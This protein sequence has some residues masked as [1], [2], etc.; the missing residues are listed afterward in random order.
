MKPF[1]FVAVSLA[2]VLCGAAEA[3]TAAG[4]SA[5]RGGVSAG[6][7]RLNVLSAI[8]TAGRYTLVPTG[9]GLC[10]ERNKFAPFPSYDYIKLGSDIPDGREACK[11]VCDA[12]VC[13]AFNYAPAGTVYPLG[14]R[15]WTPLRFQIQFPRKTQECI[16]YHDYGE[17]LPGTHAYHK[18][19]A[20]AFDFAP[21]QTKWW[22]WDWSWANGECWVSDW[23]Q[24]LEA[25]G[26]TERSVSLW[27][28]KTPDIDWRK[29]GNAVV[30]ETGTAADLRKGY[31]LLLSHMKKNAVRSPYY[32]FMSK[33][34]NAP[35]P[36]G[37]DKMDAFLYAIT[38]IRTDYKGMY[39]RMGKMS[40]SSDW[41]KLDRVSNL[42]EFAVL[43]LNKQGGKFTQDEM[44]AYC[45]FM[46]WTRAHGGDGTPTHTCRTNE[47]PNVS[48]P[49]RPFLHMVDA[50]GGAALLKQD[51]QIGS[52]FD[53]WGIDKYMNDSPF[54]GW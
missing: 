33:A 29:P 38:D 35:R 15:W 14:I 22:W 36:T 32:H 42:Y 17:Q 9:K 39:G 44:D 28:K 40:P 6:S 12:V 50:F 37:L 34:L 23:R 8:S 48:F 10:S 31:T 13:P 18:S 51:W 45:F 21:T 25:R 27:T 16:I 20:S 47:N 41:R 53:P 26:G 19:G 24:S 43:K 2:L 52:E 30:K 11:R 7:R 54:N 46:E 49:K 5:L 4:V 1:A 3:A